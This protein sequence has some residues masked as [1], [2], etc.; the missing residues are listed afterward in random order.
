MNAEPTR[1]ITF[2]LEAG[3]YEIRIYSD[4]YETITPAVLEHPGS[5]TITLDEHEHADVKRITT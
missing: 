3:E 4:R 1:T 2:D 5:L